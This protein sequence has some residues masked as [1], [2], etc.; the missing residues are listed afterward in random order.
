MRI[1]RPGL[2]QVM[3]MVMGNA[4]ND[5]GDIAEDRGGDR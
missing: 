5:G 4:R 3:V 2:M 1:P